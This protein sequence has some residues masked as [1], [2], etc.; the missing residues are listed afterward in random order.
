MD[1]P[2][3]S[4]N[5]PYMGKLIKYIPTEIV[6]GY[7][8]ASGFIKGAGFTPDTQFLWFC[9]VS[10]VLLILTPIYLLFSTK[11]SENC[12]AHIVCGVLAYAAWVFAGGGPFEHFQQHGDVGWYNRTQGS[13][14]LLLVCMLLPVFEKLVPKRVQPAASV[15]QT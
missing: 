8:A 7:A 14:V 13:I 2:T 12:Y 6:A 9:L 3:V 4:T 15:D 11:S 1:R 10:I 5:D